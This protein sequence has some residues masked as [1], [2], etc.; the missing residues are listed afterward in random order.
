M[1]RLLWFE[2]MKRHSQFFAIAGLCTLAIAAPLQ[3]QVIV[4]PQLDAQAPIVPVDAQVPV[5]PESSAPIL[6]ATPVPALPV[7]P[8]P[9]VVTTTVEPIALPRAKNLARQLAEKVNGGLS[10]YRAESA[11]YGPAVELP[12]VDNGN[13]WTFT[14]KGG[15]PAEPLSIESAVTVAKDA[16]SITLDYNGPIR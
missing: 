10:N 14:F 16:S 8:R 4:D 6:P 5:V 15:R 7:T 3:A 12:V 13:A 1:Y 2:H 11:M 9:S